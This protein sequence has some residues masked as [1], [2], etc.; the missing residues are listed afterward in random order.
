MDT[1]GLEIGTGREPIRTCPKY[2][3]VAVGGGR[4]FT[5]LGGTALIRFAHTCSFGS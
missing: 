3:N 5:P 1:L 2:G 4:A